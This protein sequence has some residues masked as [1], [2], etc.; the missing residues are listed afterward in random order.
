MRLLW[1]GAWPLAPPGYGQPCCQ[2]VGLK[3]VIYDYLY[4]QS[5]LYDQ[6]DARL[7]VGK[8]GNPK[9]QHFVSLYYPLS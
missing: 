3:R 4:D 2:H 8:P 9:I 1:V 7:V 6:M 5:R